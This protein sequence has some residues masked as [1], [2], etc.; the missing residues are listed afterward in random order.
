MKARKLIIVIMVMGWLSMTLMANTTY[1]FSPTPAD[2]SGLPQHYYFTWSIDSA[3]AGGGSLAVQ[4]VLAGVLMDGYEVSSGSFD[5]THDSAVLRRSSGG[6]LPD[7]LK[8][9]VDT[10]PPNRASFGFGV[11]TGRYCYDGMVR[12][13]TTT[14]VSRGGPGGPLPSPAAVLL[15]SIGVGVVGWLR[16]RRAI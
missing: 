11:D 16:R 9:Y 2:Q 3:S 4:D 8:A 12:V 14:K 10:Y 6:T 13:V 15:G 5:L 1:M 7:D